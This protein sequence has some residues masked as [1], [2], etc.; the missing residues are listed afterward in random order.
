MMTAIDGA[1]T[2][3]IAYRAV[4]TVTS[5]DYAAILRPAIAAAADSGAGV[6]IVIELGPDFDGYSAGA[7]WDDLS[8]GS[9][10]LAEWRRC[11]LVTDHRMLAD[12]VRAVGL[13]MPGEVRVFPVAE[14]DAAMAW[15][16]G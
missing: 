5:D 1:P 4:G 11:A 2:G 10:H 15:A 6:R 12:A 8:L 7:A 13:F 16:A 3:V 14:L 9:K